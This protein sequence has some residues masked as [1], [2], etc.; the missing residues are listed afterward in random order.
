MRGTLALILF[1]L[2]PA[3]ALC[4][5]PSL[6]SI[7]PRGGQRG[8]EQVL[9]LGGARLK[10]AQ[11]ILLYDQGISVTKLEVVND[12]QVKAKI[13][14]AGDCRPGEH[15]MR[16]RTATGI[17]EMLTFWVGTLPVIAEKEPNNDLAT[18]QK[19]PINVTI[20]G[21]VD[22][23]DVDYFAF[24]AKKG[25]RITAE[26][27]GMRLGTTMFDPYVAIL[28]AKRFEVAAADDVPLLGQDAFCSVII[29]ADGTYYV[30][31]RDSAY[32]GNG[33]CNYRLHLGTFPRPTGVVPA[34]GRPGEELE[35]RFLGDLGGEFK[36]KMKL[37][38]PQ[39]GK[40][41][42]FPQ[43]AGG[44]APSPI[45]FRIV[46]LPNVVEVEGSSN[47][48]TATRVPQLPAALNGVISKAGETDYFRFRAKKGQAFDV[49]CYARRLGSALDP[50]MV[51]SHLNGGAL[52]ANDD[53]VGP[54]S[55]FRF[56]APEDKEYVIQVT[57]HLGKGGPGYFYRIE[58]TPVRPSVTVTIPKVDIFGYSQERQT[59]TV[60]RGNRYACLLVA[61][62][63]DF[64]GELELGAEGLPAGVAM[65]AD[66]MPAG[67]GS[68]P[69]VFEANATAPVA[70]SLAQLTARH[71]DPKQHIKGGFEQSVIL[72]G[73]GNVGIF[74]KRDVHRAAV[75]VGEEEPFKIDI[76][77]PKVPLVQSGSMNLKIVAKRKAGFKAPITI[78][79][80]FNPPGIG[81]AGS[82]VIGEGQTE[83]VLPMNAA[84]NAE[85]RKWKTAVL[86]VSDAGRGPI[87]VSSQLA[88]IEVAPP[89][90][91]FAMER[92]AG[93]QGKKAEL[94]VKVQPN[95]PFQ[96][97]AKVNLIGAPPKVVAPEV[98]I[99]K[100]TKEFSFKL[101][102]D[103]TS[104]PGQHKNLFCQMIAMQN[105]EPVVHNIGSS[106]LRIDVPLP[107][108]A[109]EPAKT[110]VAKAAAPVQPKRLSRLEQLRLEQEEREKAAKK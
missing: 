26:I 17:T 101:S 90:V 39:P 70:G 61:N 73:V 74:W 62:R 60:P 76:V 75:A 91:T 102:I 89:F 48:Q 82:A 83:T 28:D 33:A 18:A 71:A 85:T 67:L 51:L 78:L 98:Q 52:L 108:K 106:E 96:G 79:P 95:T 80:L 43:D 31:V 10:D 68:I 3:A 24:D 69:V 5:T 87:W 49:H 1:A 44:M 36:Q 9:V 21:V 42:V 104:P 19:V 84:G 105:G 59:I 65:A 58:F 109:N 2:T 20:A 94:F 23:E 40:F 64:G 81:S 72:V 100:D 57:D 12:S 50:V 38:Q 47:H 37:P 15:A 27:E 22:T 29:P 63:I 110:S 93:E 6:G 92:T 34:G 41:G 4:S 30:Q 66:K 54:D 35:V 107:P 103:K 99:D 25:Q 7:M 45:P 56:T 97:K 14:I 32:G 55:Y 8:T 86:A 16:L 88:T 77:E 13:K 46:D 53:A 11:E